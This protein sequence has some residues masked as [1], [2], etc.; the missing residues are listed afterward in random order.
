[1]D[2]NSEPII[3]QPNETMETPPAPAAKKSKTK[4]IVI[5]VVL[6]LLSPIIII[7][8]YFG[9]SNLS[10]GI[11]DM[12][13][14][15]NSKGEYEVVAEI[16]LDAGLSDEEVE[17]IRKDSLGP[18]ILSHA[19]YGDSLYLTYRLNNSCPLKLYLVKINMAKMENEWIRDIGSDTACYDLT[20][21]RSDIGLYGG[22]IIVSSSEG[23]LPYAKAYDKDG[24]LLDEETYSK[25]IEPVLTSP[26]SE[27]EVLYTDG[28]H[29]KT[30][31][32]MR[33]ES[34]MGSYRIINK[35]R[36][37][38]IY[39]GDEMKHGNEWVKKGYHAELAD[40]ILSEDNK[41]Y[42]SYY[43]VCRTGF[44]GYCDGGE[45]TA[46]REYDA[47]GELISEHE[48]AKYVPEDDGFFI[49]NSNDYSYK[50]EKDS[51]QIIKISW[52]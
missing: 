17:Y 42:I 4:I 13:A 34:G 38:V 41:S 30:D 32:V 48:M 11:T 2:N 37:A 31:S 14:S 19:L 51:L 28:I 16:P 8:A 33:V 1:M 47:K 24:N 10:K 29:S 49:Y 3:S 44:M 36:S 26:T 43:H 46:R 9:I 40:T 22:N 7:L 12:I 39:D 45:S 23:R 50:N 25:L 52:Q 15:S 35:K 6:V 20:V 5:I 21:E 18:V 27:G